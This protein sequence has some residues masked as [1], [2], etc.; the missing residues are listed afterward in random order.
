MRVAIIGSG[1][2]AFGL[3]YPWLQSLENCEVTVITR[4]SSDGAT[5]DDYRQ[6]LREQREYSIQTAGVNRLQAFDGELLQYSVDDL[7]HLTSRQAV[8]RL[9]ETDILI[10]SVGATRLHNV[11]GLVERAC[12]RDSAP[13]LHI[14]AFENLPQASAGLAGSVRQAS[15]DGKL[16]REI[17]AYT[18]IPDRAC[19]RGFSEGALV[20]EWLS[21]R[22]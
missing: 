4:A 15:T 5:S 20:I 10:V 12:R 21:C 22:R 13:P 7:D 14:L 11:A 19:T 2:L 3:I 9:E 17:H 8:A 1:S 6:S 16:L 18:V